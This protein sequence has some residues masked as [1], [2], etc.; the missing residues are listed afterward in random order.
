[1]VYFDVFKD[2]K[3]FS[4]QI[5]MAPNTGKGGV[6]LLPCMLAEAYTVDLIA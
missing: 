3:G 4:R 6:I 5:M 1:M 2:Q